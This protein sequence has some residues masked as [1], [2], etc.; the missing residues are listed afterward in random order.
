MSAS[1]RRFGISA[2]AALFL[3][4]NFAGFLIFTMLPVILSL[5]MAFC[6]WSLK[7]AAERGFV[8]ARNFVD[9][10]WV[11]PVAAA[12][13]ATGWPL[14]G[15]VAA[16]VLLLAGLLGLLWA[17]V[18]GWSGRR[19]AALPLCALGMVLT[20]SQ[21]R[22]GIDLF[23][24]IAG[25]T[26]AIGGAAVALLSEDSWRPGKALLPVL[27]LI[28]A[29]IGLHVFAPAMWSHYQPR[30]PRFWQ[31]LYNTLFLMLGIPPSIAGS[32]GLA[33]LLNHDLRLPAERMRRLAGAGLCIFCGLAT[34]V[35]CIVLDWGNA[36]VVG[37][38]LWCALALGC[39]TGMVAFRTIYYLP[40]F[41]AGVAIMILWKALY[42]PESG[43]IN[44]VLQFCY[45]LFG[46]D[47]PTPDWLGSILWAKPALI[48]MGIWIAVGGTNM[49]LYLSALS[50]V[51]QHLLEAAEIDGAGWWAKF[52][53][54]IW[55]Q[56][57]PATFFILIMSVIGGFQGGFEQARVM[58]GGGPAGETT[59]LSYYIYNKAF[60]ELDLGYAAAVS[61]VLFAIIFVATA[62]NWRFGKEL[63]TE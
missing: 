58:T 33:L 26:A 48:F 2:T 50:N 11:D 12:A 23:I 39:A 25:L 35:L 40:S 36:G 54:V 6:N 3:L 29:C 41:T 8:G 18:S 42:N 46:L 59:T 14:F 56:V 44:A 9:L 37:M 5:V 28:L 24:L 38:V 21:C 47:L 43:A 52:R 61:W 53:H 34:L 49:L 7:P 17:S 19:V 55:P 20:L 4:P 63:E 62:I 31:Y 22:P 13:S 10:L 27:A 51:P 15:Y 45:N 30:D 32:L 16:C 60:E 57:L 1:G